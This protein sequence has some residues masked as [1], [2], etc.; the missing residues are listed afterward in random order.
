MELTSRLS[1]EA[2]RQI[3]EKLTAFVDAW[4]AKDLTRF[5]S[6]F[7][8]NAE[9]TDVVGQT[10]IGKEAIIEQ[11]VFPFQ[12]VMKQATLEL[13]EGY[14]RRLTDDLVIV[15][16][17]WKVTG[18]LTPDGKPLPDRNGVLQIIFRKEMAE[19]PILL[20]H[21]ADNALP[22]DRQARFMGKQ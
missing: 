17:K 13:K 7:A 3:E 9:F 18:S 14:A 16:A 19:Y 2:T 15:S 20:V 21:N 11:H 10:A 22:Y 6:L 1:V 4:N 8:E 12:R 5:G